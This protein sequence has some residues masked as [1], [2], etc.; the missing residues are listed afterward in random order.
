MKALI[1][2][3][4]QPFHKGHAELIKSV[5]KEYDELIIG[6]GSA[7]ISHEIENP[8]TAEE[9]A[10]MI[11][12]FLKSEEI[13]NFY[14]YEIPDISILQVGKDMILVWRRFLNKNNLLTDPN[15]ATFEVIYSAGIDATRI[16]ETILG[17]HIKKAND[18]G[19]LSY[20]IITSGISSEEEPTFFSTDDP[21]PDWINRVISQIPKFDVVLS[22]NQLTKELFSKAGY[23]VKE[24]PLFNREEYSG[25]EIRRRIINNESWEDLVPKEVCN[26]I[27]ELDGVKRVKDL[28][29]K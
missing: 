5:S 17:N 7:Q 15:K 23:M 16:N 2:G 24:T 27:K 25:K 8:F 9:R 4:F 3:R 14:I 11:K 13:I 19:K 22:N 1:I 21:L 29:K 6:I 28:S 12:K 18:T 10:R 20:D 26:I